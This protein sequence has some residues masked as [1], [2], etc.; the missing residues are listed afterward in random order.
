MV[1]ALYSENNMR[2]CPKTITRNWP[3]SPLDQAHAWR[4]MEGVHPILYVCTYIIGQ[5]K[6]VDSAP[7]PG[8][9][10]SVTVGRHTGSTAGHCCHVNTQLHLQLHAIK[11][12]T[13]SPQSLQLHMQIVS[14]QILTSTAHKDIPMEKAY[15]TGHVSSSTI[16]CT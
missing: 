2:L 9:M 13:T 10:K 15:S 14:G 7:K 5:I 16:T 8:L 6:A 4:Y 12:E 1:R 3:G 11:R